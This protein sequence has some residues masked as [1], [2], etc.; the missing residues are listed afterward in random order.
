MARWVVL[1]SQTGSEILEVSRRLNRL[2]DVVIYN[3]NFGKLPPINVELIEVLA[4]KNQAI[5]IVPPRPQLHNYLKLLQKGDL[6]TLHGWLRIVP[7]EICDNLEVYNGHPGLINVYPVL[8][9]KDPQQKAFDLGL[10]KSG[11]VIHKVSPV[12]DDGEILLSQEVGIEGLEVDAIIK[13]LHDT[14][15]DLW[16]KFLTEKFK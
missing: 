10:Q 1:F 14:S 6:V 16:V 2:P 12:V 7:P 11:C 8:K 13:K 4:K 9:G 15:V 5:E 3:T